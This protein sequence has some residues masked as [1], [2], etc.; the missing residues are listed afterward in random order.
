MLERWSG[1]DD[2]FFLFENLVW[3]LLCPMELTG[4]RYIKF[5]L[6][7]APP[8]FTQLHSE[9]EAQNF[10]SSFMAV[11]PSP[12]PSLRSVLPARYLRQQLLL[13]SCCIRRELLSL[14]LCLSL[15]RDELSLPSL[16]PSCPPSHSI[17]ERH[18][19]F[20]EIKLKCA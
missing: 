10:W 1:W 17:P 16:R 15:S 18:N 4:E 13:F 19:S 14:S 11:R 3:L 6:F 2:T 5:P 8:T 20:R 7:E 12:V 9:K